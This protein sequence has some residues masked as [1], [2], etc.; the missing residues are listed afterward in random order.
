MS[1]AQRRGPE[2]EGGI[3]LLFLAGILILGW[4][5]VG[6]LTA[7]LREAWSRRLAVCGSRS[8]VRQ[9]KV[10]LRKPH[11]TTEQGFKVVRVGIWSSFRLRAG[12]SR[13][14]AEPVVCVVP[15]A[16]VDALSL[17]L[18]GQGSVRIASDC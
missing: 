10:A 7:L 18:S 15:I 3:L 17:L 14:S 9:E 11:R 1:R 13:D 6:L 8:G 12:G 2:G 4:G 5:C 16:V